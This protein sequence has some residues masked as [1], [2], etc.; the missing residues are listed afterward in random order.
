MVCVPGNLGIE[1]VCTTKMHQCRSICN[2][3]TKHKMHPWSLSCL[4][5]VYCGSHPWPAIYGNMKV[6]RF[7]VLWSLPDLKIEGN[8]TL[9]DDTR[10]RITLCLYLF[11]L[12][13]QC[14]SECPLSK[15]AKR[16]AAIQLYLMDSQL[17]MPVSYKYLKWYNEKHEAKCD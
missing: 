8:T 15:T 2:F 11:Y 4:V 10:W 3:K 9:N 6:L 5:D 14:P 13:M 17:L 16:A 12:Y 7:Y 1:H